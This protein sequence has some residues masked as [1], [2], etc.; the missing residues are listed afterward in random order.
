MPT[1]IDCHAGSVPTAWGPG[2]S[3]DV[4]LIVRRELRFALWKRP[5]DKARK[6]SGEKGRG[7]LGER[8]WTKE[9]MEKNRRPRER[10]KER[11]GERGKRGK[12]DSL[13]VSRQAAPG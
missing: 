11:R 9:E 8:R 4:E 10:Q 6:G 12:C 1:A 2:Q 5:E 7:R 3:L 13:P